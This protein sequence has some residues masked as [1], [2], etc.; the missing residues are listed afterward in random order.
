M[1]DKTMPYRC[2]LCGHVFSKYEHPQ[3]HRLWCPYKE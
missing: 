2:I 1:T 3:D